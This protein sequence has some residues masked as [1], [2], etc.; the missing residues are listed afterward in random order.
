MKDSTSKMASWLEKY[1]YNP[2]EERIKNLSR[3]VIAYDDIEMES[4]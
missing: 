4:M 3:D 1:S 2:S